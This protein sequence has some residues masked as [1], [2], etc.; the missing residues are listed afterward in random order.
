MKLDSSIITETDSC[1]RDCGRI[2][3]AFLRDVGKL[4][5]NFASILKNTEPTLS[6]V[7]SD[8]FTYVLVHN[9]MNFD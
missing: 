2:I 1:A 9:S 3:N 6:I 8:L 5:R 4:T 7:G